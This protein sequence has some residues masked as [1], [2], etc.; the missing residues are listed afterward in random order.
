LDLTDPTE[1]DMMTIS[2]TGHDHPATPA[3]RA[4]CR[5]QM[6]NGDTPLTGNPIP[7]TIDGVVGKALRP[8]KLTVVPRRRGDGGVVKGMQTG[9]L[10]V[11]KG[12]KVKAYEKAI[13]TT[14]DLPA[15]IPANLVR[16]IKRAWERGW[17]VVE[18]M[19][20]N[21][22]ETRILIGGD[23]A[24]VSLVFNAAGGSGV[25]VRSLT[26]SITHRV[27]YG[28]Q[29]LALASGEDEWPW[30]NGNKLV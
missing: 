11:V 27:D 6:A 18:G 1:E 8:A 7:S 2:H 28:S 17:A 23:I 3:A 25:F 5:K 20:L 21:D 9:D 13:R 12:T 26:S 19:P 16:T 15:D 14:G 22:N 24:Q 30:M 10:G 29:A 4:A